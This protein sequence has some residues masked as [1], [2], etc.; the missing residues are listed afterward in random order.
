MVRTVVMQVSEND[1]YYVETVSRETFAVMCRGDA[2]CH[3]VHMTQ[4][5]LEA[6]RM[7]DELERADR[8]AFNTGL[9]VGHDE[10]ACRPNGQ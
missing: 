2:G 1:K 3:A 5:R 7:R 6:L 4:S 9:I 8:R 10:K